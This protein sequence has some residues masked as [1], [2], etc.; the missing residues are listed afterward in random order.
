MQLCK[1]NNLTNNDFRNYNTLG[2]GVVELHQAAGVEIQHALPSA[3]RYQLAERLALGIVSPNRFCTSYEI[4]L[5]HLRRLRTS[6]LQPECQLLELRG[7]QTDD[8][9][10]N[11]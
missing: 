2:L 7:G 6:P 4:R 9:R 8:G 11:L 5:R 10:F 3:L 1:Y